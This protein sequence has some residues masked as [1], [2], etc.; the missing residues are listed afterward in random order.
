MIGI[1]NNDSTQDFTGQI[2][3][4]EKTVETRRTDSLRPYVGRRVGIVR[5]GLGRAMLV[6]YA[7]IGEPIRYQ[8]RRQ[9]AADFKRH[10]VAPDSPHDCGA[11]AKL[12][13]PL[14]NVESTA[15]R[16]V[17]S[18]GIVARKI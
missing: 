4:G 9:F 3:R 1:N 8:N 15:P 7:T 5:T 14:T 17:T 2:L 11:G 13:Y 10:R 6:G 12:G 16:P 18:R